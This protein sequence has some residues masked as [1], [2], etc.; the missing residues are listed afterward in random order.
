MSDDARQERHERVAAHRQQLAP[1]MVELQRMGFDYPTLDDLRRSH[2]VYA[3]AVPVLV[4]WLQK[5][6]G[7][8]EKEAIVRTLSVPWA[9]SGATRVLLD[10]FYR[11][12]REW[13]SLKWAIGNAMDCIADPTVSAE[14]QTIAA[15]SS[16]GTTRQMFILA[17]GKVGHRP[18]IPTL[19]RLLE[20]DDVAGHA[21]MALGAM[22]AREASPMIERLAITGKP[23]IRRVATTALKRIGT[24]VQ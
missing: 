7:D 9:D 19:I 6:T 13:T 2:T 23:W 1:L 14:M 24:G 18:S 12:P 11:A 22:A 17:L 20:D 5:V 3:S 10:E 21:V 8:H 16:H 4:H 15:D